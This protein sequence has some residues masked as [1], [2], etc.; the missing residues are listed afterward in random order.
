MFYLA[1]LNVLVPCHLYVV[2]WLWCPLGAYADMMNGLADEHGEQFRPCQLMMD[3]A[4][5]NK[6]F[7]P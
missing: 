2:I 6:K 1:P 7:H 5:D 3:H 4:K